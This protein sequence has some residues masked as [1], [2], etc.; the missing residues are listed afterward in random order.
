MM[1][2]YG[3][4]ERILLF[5]G[6]IY[7]IILVVA[8]GYFYQERLMN[9]DSAFYTFEIIQKN[10]FYIAHNRWISYFTEWVP[11]LAIKLGC[12]YKTILISY[13][14]SLMALIY[15][16]Y[17]FIA[18]GIRNIYASTL[19]VATFGAMYRYKFYAG[20]SEIIPA[21]A[22]GILFIAFFTRGKEIKTRRDNHKEYLIYLLCGILMAISHPVPIF[23]IVLIYSFWIVYYK[24]YKDWKSYSR[25]TAYILPTVLK[26]LIFK[27]GSYESNKLDLLS[28]FSEVISYP[29]KY[30]VYQVMWNYIQDEHWFTYILFL[31]SLVFLLIKKKILPFLI[32]LISALILITLNLVTFSYLKNN[33]YLMI[34]GYMAFV[35]LVLCYF[36][37]IELLKI[38]SL[39]KILLPVLLIF[40]CFNLA[41]I[42]HCRHFFQ[43]R[44]SLI[45]GTFKK[46]E[47]DQ[48]R[49][50]I[51]SIDYTKWQRLWYVWAISPESI[52]LSTLR[53]Q[54]STSVLYLEK[55]DKMAS[56]EQLNTMSFDEKCTELFWL[57]TFS[58][59]NSY[60]PY[61]NI[62]QDSKAIRVMQPT[63]INDDET[64]SIN[65]WIQKKK[66]EKNAK[67]R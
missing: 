31:L 14:V 60:E 32:L 47:S 39:K 64:R 12:S 59:L 28:Q 3:L 42:Y 29:E 53:G 58:N 54:D 45:E 40:F 7:F 62:P 66:E 65:K 16:V 61:F 9:F 19:L 21:I 2:K 48:N 34:D 52:L 18:H 57:N 1:K 55:Y 25:I 38:Q 26:L 22:F 67:K 37:C 23:P 4:S 41:R 44:M 33:C 17:I 27:V 13:S 11:L 35:G 49:I 56:V 43:R 10:S 20:V 50:L 15:L 63:W 6:H 8:A 24:K 5:T 36:I 51:T 30:H 46:Y